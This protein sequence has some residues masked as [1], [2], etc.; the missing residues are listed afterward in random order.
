[1]R[2][3]RLVRVNPPGQA[4]W[5]NAVQSLLPTLMESRLKSWGPADIDAQQGC[6]FYNGRLPQEITD[7]IFEF[8]LSPDTLPNFVLEKVPSHDLCV[9]YDH[10][11]SRDEPELRPVAR[12]A[13]DTDAAEVTNLAAA[14]TSLDPATD[15]GDAETDVGLA[16][17]QRDTFHTAS[18]K[19]ASGFDWYRPDNTGQHVFH[20]QELLRTCRRIYLD[21]RKLLDQA[22]DV[23]IYDGREPAWG[24]GLKVLIRKLRVNYS[25]QLPRISSIR[26]FVQMYR[27][28]SLCSCCLPHSKTAFS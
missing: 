12:Q 10:E 17:T 28:V 24:W 19:K 3:G 11:R 1:M 26:W 8:A 16:V 20:G 23:A 15:A 4:E 22:R 13:D 9:R 7:L 27:L 6:P 2:N 14:A 21:A 5:Y 18:W 25:R